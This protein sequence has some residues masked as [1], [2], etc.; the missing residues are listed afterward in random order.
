MRRLRQ[1]CASLLA[2]VALSETSAAIGQPLGTFQWQQQ[3]YCNVF[4]LNIVQSGGVYQ[5]DGTDDQCGAARKAAVVGLGFVNPNGT[6]GLGLTVITNN[7]GAI[8]GVPLHLDVVLNLPSA[9]GTW[10][11]AAGNSGVFALLVGAPSG[12]PR[13]APGIGAGGA[14]ITGVATPT[15]STDAANKSYVDGLAATKATITDVR[16]AMLRNKAWSAGVNSDGTKNGAGRF[17]TSRLGVGSYTVTFDLTGY[18]LPYDGVFNYALAPRCTGFTAAVGLR[19]G[20]SVAG[21]SATQQASITMTNAAGAAA[22]C[23]AFV[24]AT[25]PDPDSGSPVP[26]LIPGGTRGGM[27]CATSGTTTTCIERPTP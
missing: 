27:T 25:N 10:R 2:L 21:I 26:P 7:G 15:A 12:S 14:R 16:A 20:T 17:S 19:L 4:A 18:N 3:P 8:G 13:P 24:I 22:D 9:S 6:I 5:L 23:G 1:L 11:D